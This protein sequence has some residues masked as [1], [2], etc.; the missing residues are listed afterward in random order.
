MLEGATRFEKTFFLATDLE[1]VENWS[2]PDNGEKIRI[3]RESF[4]EVI[5]RCHQREMRQAEAMLCVMNMAYDPKA[6]A[7]LNKWLNEK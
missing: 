2:N 3:E 4:V 5:Q 1:P 6:K 7:E